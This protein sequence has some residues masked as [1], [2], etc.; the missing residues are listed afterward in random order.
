VARLPL[1]HHGSNKAGKPMTCNRLLAVANLLPANC[2][3]RRFAAIHL[4]TFSYARAFSD[5]KA[6][7]PAAVK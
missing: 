1:G 6:S 4:R 7:Y 2:R 5:Q 3:D